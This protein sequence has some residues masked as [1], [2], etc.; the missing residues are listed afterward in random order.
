MHLLVNTCCLRNRWQLVVAAGEKDLVPRAK[1]HLSFVPKRKKTVICQQN[2]LKRRRQDQTIRP[3]GVADLR[4]SAAEPNG[5]L[6]R[7]SP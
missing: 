1:T 6:T 3:L 2:S 5:E 7:Q 4:K